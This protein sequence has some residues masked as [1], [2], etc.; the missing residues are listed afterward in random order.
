MIHLLRL[1]A[2]NFKQ[3]QEIDLQFPEHARVLVQGK[4]EA[5]K[6]TLFEAVFF[7]LFGTAL[8]TET[9]SRGLGD[10]IRYGIEKAEVELDA[11]VG[12]RVFKIKRK[13]V[14]DKTNT[15]ELD[16]IHGDDRDEIRG[17]TTVN[18][19]LIDEL[20]FDG[21][22]L[23]NTC[24]VEQKKLEKL[25]G[26]SKNKREESLAKLLNLDALLDL[27]T[28][29][30][31]SGDDKRDLERLRQRA[32]LAEVQDELPT[33]ESELSAVENKLKLI[34]LR[35]VV[36]GATG[37]LRAV[38]QLDAQ[39][40]ALGEQRAQA[41]QRVARL[42]PLR[43]A[44]VNVK[45]ALDASERSEENARE[46]ERI[47]ADLS[48]LRRSTEETP[49]LETRSRNLARLSTLLRWLDQ[50]RTARDNY[51]QRAEQL[52]G[53]E[54]R[55][56]DLAATASAEE[57]ILAKIEARLHQ[58]EIGEALGEWIAARQAPSAGRAE[59]DAREKQTARDRISRRFQVEVVGFVLL[60]LAF[61]A[62]AVFVEPLALVSFVL[63]VLTAILLAARVMMLWRALERAAQTLGQALGEAR[64][65]ANQA[66][67]QVD[68]AEA[69]EARL[70][71]L[72]ATIPES[73]D[74]AQARRVMI[75]REM[76]N[77]TGNELHAEQ[78]ASHERLLNARAVLGELQKQHALDDAAS[79]QVER[80]R[81][82]RMTKKAGQILSRWEPR[83]GTLAKSLGVEMETSVVQRAR[84]QLDAQ[85][86]QTSRRANDL[87]KLE[88]EISRRN[89]Q[90]KSLGAKAREAYENARTA[91]GAG[92]DRALKEIPAWNPSLTIEDYSTFGKELRRQYDSQGGEQAGKQAR[93]IEGELGRREGER[94]TR[95]RNAAESIERARELLA[96]IGHAEEL[97]PSPT[98]KEVE[99]LGR[100]FASIQLEDEATLSAQHRNL[101]GRVHSLH[102]RRG[103][104][105]QTLGLAGEVLDRANCRIEL[106]EKERSLKVRDR[107]AE[108]VSMARHRIVQKVLPATMD[109]MRRILPALTRDRYHDAQL[110]EE[111]YKIQVWDERAGGANGQGGAFKE[112]NI[113]SGGTKD[114]FSL[115]LRLA[116]ALATLPQERGSAP[117]FIFLDEP[118]GS[119][120]EE[121]AD[122]LIS[123]LTEGEIAHAFDQIFLISHVHVDER[124]FT[125]RVMM[126]AG[127]IAF[128][129]LPSA[130][131]REDTEVEVRTKRGRK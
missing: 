122:A 49:K 14:R 109:Y 54:T 22:A 124:L 9:G 19:R 66:Q 95:A 88:Q 40:R 68:R 105:E 57:A 71:Q 2:H 27:E 46:I 28:D 1:Y 15:W 118:L 44:M 130:E 38:G 92:G 84:F 26:M 33:R 72:G 98:L 39:I 76:E 5:G 58:Y 127:R 103:A 94:Q 120:D 86:E 55:L 110:D 11:Q 102:D 53:A 64:A 60:L 101:V 74:I 37:E 90:A 87:A 23:L 20:G 59:T 41:A 17:N 112:K 16:I 116:F 73:I 13:L 62:G 7:A 3:L 111:S 81:C 25:E 107:G 126:E 30:K 34:E 77:K 114:Q 4:N 115:A 42:V 48:Q 125:H 119:F 108:I 18:K 117:S 69:T 21:D 85:L 89:E 104:L 128:T 50:V 106:E 70:A 6:S 32:E 99:A 24:F 131:E 29:F 96:E 80:T 93:E 10:L 97:S 129:D 123:L 36:E 56:G 31:V 67:A 61:L 45:A 63:A 79:V 100:R 113:F 47:N 82:E 65:L 51:A 8:V 121:R 12:T 35:S 43:N 78:A 83:L 91:A 75:A 52:A